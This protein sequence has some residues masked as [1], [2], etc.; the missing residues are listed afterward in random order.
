MA[1]FTGRLGAPCPGS[2][3]GT[4]YEFGHSSPSIEDPCPAR[5][6]V[7]EPIG[8]DTNAF[9]NRANPA[10][11]GRQHCADPMLV[12]RGEQ[13]GATRVT[14]LA[15]VSTTAW[16]TV[17]LLPYEVAALSVGYHVGPVRAGWITTA[18]LLALA[19]AASYVGQSIARHDKRR[20]T[21]LGIAIAAAA[22]IGCL[23][24]DHVA[25]IIAFRLLFGVGTGIIAAATN[26]LPALHHA[27]K[28]LFAYMQLALG[29][30]FGLAIFVVGAVQSFAGRDAVFCVDLL[31]LLTLGPAAFLLPKGNVSELPSSNTRINLQ[32]PTGAASSLAALGLMWIAQG[33]LWAFAATAGAEAGLDPDSLVRWLSIAGFTTPFGAVAAAVLG[34]RRGYS[35][36]LIAGF[37]VQVL[38]AL[39]MYCSFSRSFYIAGALVSNM[40]TT[41]TTPY[42]QGVLASLDGTGRATALS[43][44]A[45]NFGAAVGP[46]LGA[47]LVAQTAAPIGITSTIMLFISLGLA[48]TSLRSLPAISHTRSAA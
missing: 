40:T 29:V 1:N 5:L 46:A 26:A 17:T 11:R 37:A 30:V 27:P 18:E 12:I 16:L 13:F 3:C 22:A 38:V 36:P 21:L 15:V 24:T 32:L 19:C 8:R 47:M 39:A 14:A 48:L 4:R 35:A 20:L 6:F 43:G 33:A 10:T 2:G 9:Q 28:K 45:A 23:S 25:L 7:E 42:L 31:L 41:F 44:A 34:E